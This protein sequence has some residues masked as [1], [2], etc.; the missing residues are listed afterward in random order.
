MRKPMRIVIGVCLTVS[1]TAIILF[2]TWVTSTQL[3]PLTLD[4]SQTVVDHKGELLRAYTVSDGR[5][6][7][8]V[9]LIDVDH[10]YL[11]YLIRFEDKRFY[12]HPGVDVLA[13][14]R[15]AGQALLNGRI[16]SGASTLTM[17]VARL[18]EQGNSGRWEG[19]IRQLRVALALENVLTKTEILS[20]YLKLA[21]FGGNLEGVRAASLAYFG[22]EP[23]RLTPAQAALLV[24]LPQ[25]PENRRPDRAAE[26]AFTI[27]NRVLNRLAKQGLLS[28]NEALAAM[29]EKIPNKRRPFPVIAPHLSDRK[30]LE[31]PLQSVTKTN[32][33]K[34]LQ[35]SLEQLAKETIAN[36]KSGMSIALLVMDHQT[37]KLLASVGSADYFDQERQGFVDMTNAIRSP[38]SVL[39]PIIYGL[40]FD[41][42]LVH[43]ETLID[44]RPTTYGNYSPQN[45]DKRFRGTLRVRESLQQSLNIPTV[46]L[47][48]AIG[49]AQ[50]IARITGAGVNPVLP[51]SQL[52]GLAIGLGGIGL[53]LNELVSLYAAIANGGSPLNKD[54]N[55]PLL[56]RVTNTSLMSASAAWHIGDILSGVVEPIH[57]AKNQL[58]YKTGTSYGHRDGWALGFDGKHVIGVWTGRPDGAS[59]PGMFGSSVAAPILFDAFSR[60]KTKLTPLPPPPLGTVLV[61][62]ANLPQPLK[63]FRGRNAVFG[64]PVNSPIITF[65]PDGT[66]VD[67]GYSG[68]MQQPLV[69]KVRNGRPPFTWIADGLP[70]LIAVHDRQTSFTPDGP[71]YLNLAVIDSDGLSQNIRIAVD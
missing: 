65:P 19:K 4:T 27:R 2:Q 43:P 30:I 68:N 11:R 28:T 66:R 37:G 26:I 10:H 23:K 45:F 39:K 62:N 24:S 61:D 46:S 14:I 6:R 50:L 59:L 52:P 9:D 12:S 47:L 36:D 71:G 3:P 58:A 38:G 49:P 56:S 64:L 16:V 17:Q 31:N 32:V 22:K 40:A 35:K 29:T 54:K 15:A 42:G 33:I 5:W 51:G 60:L 67:L 69:L 57:S 41:Q 53:T 20:L 8:P 34:T 44:D 1:L 7:L 25:S 13:I 18:L 70:V 63:R 21:P 55:N 48:Q